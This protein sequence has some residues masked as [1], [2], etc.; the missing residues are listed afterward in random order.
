LPTRL[1]QTMPVIILPLP[2]TS[3]HVSHLSLASMCSLLRIQSCASSVP[4]RY[5]YT[6]GTCTT[7]N[8]S[9]KLW[10]AASGVSASLRFFA[11]PIYR[12]LT[13]A[14]EDVCSPISALAESM[15][16][17]TRTLDCRHTSPT[18]IYLAGMTAVCMPKTPSSWSEVE[19]LR[20]IHPLPQR[21]SIMLSLTL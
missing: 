4:R 18:Q 12:V 7:T 1:Q 9:Y 16:V 6:S 19:I 3:I 20:R 5:M 8:S 14:H 11:R 15:S 13:A 2:N 17:G 10:K 21:S